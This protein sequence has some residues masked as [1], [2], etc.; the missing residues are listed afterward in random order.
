MNKFNPDDD[1]MD[2]T[3]LI[4]ELIENNFVPPLQ[5][6]YHL[7]VKGGDQLI[8]GQSLASAEIGEGTTLRILPT[9]EAGTF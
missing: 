6:G 4:E 7:M 2:D 9:T 8:R 3:E 5:A 1:A